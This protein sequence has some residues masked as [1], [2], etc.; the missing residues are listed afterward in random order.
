[1]HGISFLQMAFL[2]DVRLLIILSLLNNS[3]N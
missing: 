3:Y 2:P 1:M